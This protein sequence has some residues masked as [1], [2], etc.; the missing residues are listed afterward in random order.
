MKALCSIL[1]CP[2][3]GYKLIF[4]IFTVNFCVTAASKIEQQSVKRKADEVNK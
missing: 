4:I 1:I 3:L 2:K